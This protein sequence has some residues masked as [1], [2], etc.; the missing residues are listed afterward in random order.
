ML[1]DHFLRSLPDDPELA[2]IE[3]VDHLDKWLSEETRKAS[4]G[5]NKLSLEHNY[6]S[7]RKYAETLRAFVDEHD[8]DVPFRRCLRTDFPS[9]DDWWARFSED[10]AYSRSR[11]QFRHK[12]GP[13]MLLG[14]SVT[15][16]A[17][18]RAQIH[19]LIAKIRKVVA[20]LDVSEAKRDAIYSRIAALAKEVDQSKTI[21]ATLMGLILE[22]SGTLGEAAEKLDPLARL[23]TSA[24]VDCGRSKDRRRAIEALGPA[25]NEAHRGTW[26][27]AAA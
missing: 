12:L 6:I 7:E 11:Y 18:R 8:L 24:H 21:F 20:L 9:E 2:F 15:L 4:I 5:C 3:L 13:R 10:V 22:T 26:S 27:T 17:D 19:D 16:N 14:S 25:R 23:P 1:T